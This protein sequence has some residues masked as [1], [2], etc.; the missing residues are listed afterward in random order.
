MA[1]QS[2]PTTN[3]KYIVNQALS[4]S[5]DFNGPT[6]AKEAQIG[7]YAEAVVTASSSLVGAFKLQ[8]CATTA[9]NWVD[10]T[11]SS[12]SVSGNGTVSWNVSGAYYKFWRIV[13]VHT[14]GT[15]TLNAAYNMN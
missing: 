3:E 11:S 13:Y 6:V 14:S 2:Y 8:S 12:Q 4:A 10:V 7:F 15:G 9:G 5:V 1:M